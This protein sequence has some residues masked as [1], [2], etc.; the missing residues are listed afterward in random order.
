LRAHAEP[1]RGLPRAI[2]FLTVLP[3]PSRARDGLDGAAGWFALVGAGVGALAGAVRLGAQQLLGTAPASVLAIVA[4]V[5]ASG[6]LHEDGLADSAD[7]LGARGGGPARRL[8]AMRDSTTGV[9]GVP[10]LIGWALLLPSTLDS[11]SAAHALVALT[12]ACAL[13]RW[14]SLLHATATAPARPDGLGAALRVGRAAVFFGGATALAFAV[15]LCGIAAGA[16]ASGAALAVAALTA[17]LAR[18]LLGGHTGD[19]LGATVALAELA[20]CVALLA[21]WRG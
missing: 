6:A 12:V 15:T 8:E 3:M 5:L 11:L 7:G 17:L 10:A 4:L 2:A 16:A 13:A 21:C 19:T 18:R 14:A 1:W 20:A 9:F